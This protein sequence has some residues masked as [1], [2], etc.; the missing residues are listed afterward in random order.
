VYHSSLM[1]FSS[2]HRDDLPAIDDMVEISSQ[3]PPLTEFHD[4]VARQLSGDQLL[5]VNDI[6]MRELLQSTSKH[7]LAQILRCS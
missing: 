3:I 5:K 7:C 4:D 2:T 1:E 6:W